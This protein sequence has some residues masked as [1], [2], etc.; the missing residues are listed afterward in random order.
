M[1]LTTNGFTTFAAVGNR[2]D[3]ADVIH[4]ISPTDTPFISMA[5]KGKATAV[6]HEWQ[7]DALASAS[8]TNAQLEGDD[9]T[10]AASV[11]TT[12]VQN[13]CQI[14]RKSLAVSGTQE[15]VDKAGRSS[16]VAYLMAKVA[17]ELK[18]DIESVV[19]QN[20]GYNAGATTTA[21][22]T[23]SLESF[24]TT[25]V[26]RGSS[27]DTAGASATGAD[28]AAT[29]NTD[30]RAFTEA[31]LKTVIQSVWS[32]GGD[33]SVLMV[34]PVNKQYVSAFTGRSSARQNIAED[35]I[36]GAASLYASDFGELKVVPN[37]FQRERSAFVLD[38]E[39]I[40]MAWLRPYKTENLA[41]TGDSM[42][43]FIVA[44]YA[45]E[46]CNEAAHGVIADLITT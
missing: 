18:R 36:Q 33:P 28:Q 24:L 32:S 30:K 40:K 16:E 19:T 1:T 45:F 43:K 38:P 39:Y 13:Y 14:S 11:A 44:E 27:T 21:R 23:R 10:P 22:K 25:N 6:L 15:V 42:R 26:S 46:M 9:I 7:T 2:E 34:G 4:D 3:L 17:K 41:K 20:Q 5:K 35:K 29:D 31:L 8:S 37:R 12:R